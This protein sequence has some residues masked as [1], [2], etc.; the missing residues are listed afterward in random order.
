LEPAQLGVIRAHVESG[1][2][3]VGIR[4]ASHAFAAKKAE[5][6]RVTWE[7]F[8]RDVF[9]GH[10]QNHYGK[11]S[12]TLARV[13]PAAVGHPVA[14]GLPAGD[15]RFTSHL[16]RCRDLGPGTQVILEATL[17]GDP[18][19]R[20]PA[21]WLRTRGGQRHF[22]TSLGSPEDFTQPAFRRMLVNALLWAAAAPP[23]GIRP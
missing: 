2:P 22:Y 4:T 13:L 21:A 7:T 15:L 1:K 23:G 10:Y 16:Y 3:V 17:E 19:V 14:A 6:G 18:A 9:G 5:P 12:V 20:E 11:G 8:D